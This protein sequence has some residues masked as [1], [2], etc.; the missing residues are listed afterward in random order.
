[1]KIQTFSKIWYASEKKIKNVWKLIVFDDRGFLN[2][3]DDRIEF[4]GKKSNIQIKNIKNILIKRQKVN[5]GIYFIIDVLFVFY[6][7]LFFP[8]I[9]L[10]GLLILLIGNIFGLS[11][12]L[13]TKWILIEYL[14]QNN[15]LKKVYFADGSMFGWSGVFGGTK[16]IYKILKLQKYILS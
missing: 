4:N 9:I 12:A 5:W 6:V 3:Y 8:K 10:G 2:I 14:D 13:A 7:C 11:V 15:N 1:M 16:K